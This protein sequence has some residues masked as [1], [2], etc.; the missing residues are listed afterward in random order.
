MINNVRPIRVPFGNKFVEVDSPE[1]EQKLKDIIFRINR[2]DDGE[3][4]LRANR[5]ANRGQNSLAKA[6]Q[7]ALRHGIIPR[8]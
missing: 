4:L 3:C 1:T 7:T 8:C 6:L 5:L 2:F